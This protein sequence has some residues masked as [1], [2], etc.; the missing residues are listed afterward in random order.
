V[1]RCTGGWAVLV[2]RAGHPCLPGNWTS[3][4]S[5]RRRTR[6]ACNQRGR[7]HYRHRPRPR[8][9]PWSHA[10]LCLPT[11]C[12]SA[13]PTVRHGVQL[14]GGRWRALALPVPVPR[15]RHQHRHGSTDPC[16][17]NAGWQTWN[18]P[19]ALGG[20][21]TS[22]PGFAS[23]ASGL[24]DV[25]ELGPGSALYRRSWTGSSWTAWQ[26]L[27]CHWASG[28]ASSWRA[29]GHIDIFERGTDN[30]VWHL[31]LG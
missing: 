17:G 1:G 6:R 10:D 26:L 31:T 20:A 24:V 13:S 22:G 9:L 5:R 11:G 23:S 30:A 27:G 15:R 2:A 18:S 19:E 29:P 3:R 8:S 21:L 4:G 14:D 25:F 16:A 12:T 28:P 7:C